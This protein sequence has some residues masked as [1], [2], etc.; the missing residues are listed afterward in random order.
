MGANRGEMLSS[1][2][3]L[4]AMFNEHPDLFAQ[5]FGSLVTVTESCANCPNQ[6]NITSQHKWITEVGESWTR[7]NKCSLPT[8]IENHEA[9]LNRPVNHP[10][11]NCKGLMMKKTIMDSKPIQIF[12]DEVERAG[13]EIEYDTKIAWNNRVYEL[14]G[15]QHYTG[16]VSMM[17]QSGSHF[18][19]YTRCQEDQQYFADSLCPRVVLRKDDISGFITK[20]RLIFYAEI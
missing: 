19:S 1:T 4:I 15:R 8:A 20:T 16:R 17:S 14:F 7:Q 9:D 3:W 6:T 5:K 13:K 10:C 11:P 18:T 12:S 2:E